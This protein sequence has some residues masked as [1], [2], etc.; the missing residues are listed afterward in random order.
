MTF[1]YFDFK[2]LI[3]LAIYFYNYDNCKEMT[4][5]KLSHRIIDRYKESMKR[6]NYTEARA[7]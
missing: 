6:D 2:L 3:I 4:I 5:E 7:F 1:H